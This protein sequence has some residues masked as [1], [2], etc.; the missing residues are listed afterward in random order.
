LPTSIHEKEVDISLYD[1]ETWVQE[2]LPIWSKS[3]S[4]SESDCLSL[5]SITEK[6][7]SL[8]TKQY[9]GD[10]QRL[11]LMHLCILE[12]WVAL[13]RI[14]VRWCPLLAEYSPEIPED[15]VDPLLLPTLEQMGRVNRV[16]MYLRGRHK[17]NREHGKHSVF[18]D[19]NH[20]TSFANRFLDLPLA[21]PLHELEERIQQWTRAQKEAKIQELELM[22]RQARQLE[23]QML[24]TGHNNWD[25]PNESSHVAEKCQRCLIA[26][27]LKSM[28]ISPF[29]EPLP[30][31]VYR[32]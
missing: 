23:A 18:D 20:L 32:A 13:D 28:T 11:S 27:L 6:Y 4:R 7:R 12:L 17:V 26:K 14:V 19:V 10:P 21:R 9:N 5:Y 22:N 8:A 24:S 31:E 3:H 30:E 25:R 1:F 15:I 29:E 2:R 16:Q